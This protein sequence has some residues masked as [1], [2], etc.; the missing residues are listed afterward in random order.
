[1][2]ARLRFILALL[3][4]L[5]GANLSAQRAVDPAPHPD[6]PAAAKPQHNLTRLVL[7][8]RVEPDAAILRLVEPAFREHP[9]YRGAFQKPPC[10]DCTERVDRRTTHAKYYYHNSKPSEFTV[11]QSYYPL[12]YRDANGWLRTIDPRL[13]VAAADALVYE[14]PNQPAPTRLDLR[15]GFA[16]LRLPTGSELRVNETARVFIEGESG[17][18]LLGT[19]QLRPLNTKVG[20]DGAFQKSVV[21]GVDREIIFGKGS[22]K[23]NY[24]LNQRPEGMSASDRWIVEEEWTQPAGS[25]WM[26]A[27]GQGAMGRNGLWYGA[28]LLLRDNGDT[29]A[30]LRRADIHDAKADQPNRTI[31]GY[32]L[33]RE[34]G[35]TVVQL[36]VSGEWLTAA[37]VQYPVTVD[38][39]LEE[40]TSWPD[41]IPFK[42]TPAAMLPVPDPAGN[43]TCASRS[44]YC[45]TTM[46]VQLPPQ[47]KLSRVAFQ[48]MI[49]NQ[50]LPFNQGASAVAVASFFNSTCNISEVIFPGG[51]VG[52]YG[53]IRL[54]KGDKRGTQTQVGGE[55][56]ITPYQMTLPDSC[57]KPVCVP[58]TIPFEMRTYHCEC[59]T[60]NDIQCVPADVARSCMIIE[61]SDWVMVAQGNTVEPDVNSSAGRGDTL[62]V[63]QGDEVT[64]QAEAKYGVAPYIYDWQLG[65]N[66]ERAVIDNVTGFLSHRVDTLGTYQY[67]INYTDACNSG[68]DPITYTVIVRPGPS[69]EITDYKH[70]NCNGPGFVKLAVSENTDLPG[71]VL[72][73]ASCEI[74]NQP[75]SSVNQAAAELAYGGNRAPTTNNERNPFRGGYSDFRIQY[76]YPV[77]ILQA[78]G[79]QPGKIIELS[80]IQ[81]S[82]STIIP[83]RNLTIKLGCTNVRGL[84]RTAGFIPNLSTVFYRNEFDMPNV[85][86]GQP[87]VFPLDNAY[88]WD[89]TSHL[90]L[91]VCFDNESPLGGGDNVM[92][93]SFPAPASDRY[94]TV[95]WSDQPTN[96]NVSGCT[97]DAG[98]DLRN[99]YFFPVLR[100]RQC[101]GWQWNKNDGLYVST[102]PNREFDIPDLPSDPN[103]L[104]P[105]KYDFFYVDQQGCSVPV[106]IRID[107][108]PDP[109]LVVSEICPDTNGHNVRLIGSD[110]VREYEYEAR[111]TGTGTVVRSWRTDSTMFL[112]QGTYDIFIRDTS[113]CMGDAP[114]IEIGPPLE[115]VA[116]DTCSP[117]IIFTSRGGEGTTRTFRAVIESSTDTLINSDGNFGDLPPGI[118]FISVEDEKPCRVQRVGFLVSAPIEVAVSTNAC[119]STDITPNATVSVLNGSGHYRYATSENGPWQASPGFRLVAGTYTFYV[120][121]TVTGCT[122][123][124]SDVVVPAVLSFKVRRTCPAPVVNNLT[125]V[126]M[127]GGSGTYQYSVDNG[128][129]WS[130]MTAHRLPVGTHTV[131]IRDAN[132]TDCQQF[133]TAVIPDTMV[134]S[135]PC[136]TDD[137]QYVVTATGGEEPKEYRLTGTGG[138]D[139]TQANG[140]FTVL[141]PNQSGM[142]TAEVSYRLMPEDVLCV[143]SKRFELF[144]R[145]KLNEIP[146]PNDSGH[147]SLHAQGGNPA[148]YTFGWI[149]GGNDEQL[150]SGTKNPYAVTLPPGTRMYYV[151]DANGC[152]SEKQMTNI[153]R[154]KAVVS[155]CPDAD[156]VLTVTTDPAGQDVL[157]ALRGPSQPGTPQ[158]S[159]FTP[160]NPVGVKEYSIPADF[161]DGVPATYR[162]FIKYGDNE[163]FDSTVKAVNVPL[164]IDSLDIGCHVSGATVTVVVKTRTGVGAPASFRY[165][166]GD[167]PQPDDYGTA[168]NFSLSPGIHTL[169]VRD[170][171]GCTDSMSVEVVVPL[172]IDSVSA[173]PDADGNYRVHVSGGGEEF[174]YAVGENPQPGG[175]KPAPSAADEPRQLLLPASELATEAGFTVRAKGG[176]CSDFKEISAKVLKASVLTVNVTCKGD[177][178]GAIVVVIEGVV[179]AGA[180]VNLTGAVTRSKPINPL[181][182]GSAV[183]QDLPAGE[184]VIEVLNPTGCPVVLDTNRVTLSEPAD[185]FAVA[186]SADSVLC[187][188][189]SNGKIHVKDIVGAQGPLTFTLTDSEGGSGYNGPDVAPPSQWTYSNLPAGSYTL[190]VKDSLGCVA[191][192]NPDNPVIIHEPDSL[193]APLPIPNHISC[194]GGRL[195]E[196]TINPQGGTPPYRVIMTGDASRA[197]TQ[198]P[199]VFDNLDKRPDTTGRYHFKVRDAHGCEYEVP[200][201]IEIGQADKLGVEV[202]KIPPSCPDAKDGEII[203]EVTS[204]AANGNMIY[205]I[206]GMPQDTL[207]VAQVVKLPKTHAYKDLG[208]GQYRLEIKDSDS[209]AAKFDSTVYNVIPPPAFAASIDPIDAKCNGSDDGSVAVMV[210]SGGESQPVTYYLYDSANN[211]VNSQTEDQTPY[212]GYT[213]SPLPVGTYRMRV[214]YENTRGGFCE[215]T[216]RDNGAFDIKEPDRIIISNFE[217]LR[218]IS[219]HGDSALISFAVSGRPDGVEMTN[220]LTGGTL[221]TPVD[222]VD[223]VFFDIR[224]PGNYK[225]VSR[226]TSGCL[227]DTLRFTIDGPRAAFAFTGI[228][229]G[230]D[231]TCFGDNDGEFTLEVSG[232]SRTMSVPVPYRYDL[233]Y[234]DPANNETR[235]DDQVLPEPPLFTGMAPGTYTFI[236]RD[237]NNNASGN[238]CGVDTFSVEIIAKP[239]FIARSSVETDLECEGIGDGVILVERIAGGVEPVVVRLLA[240]GGAEQQPVDP[241]ANPLRYEGLSEAGVY[242]VE[243]ADAD[244][245]EATL[246]AGSASTLTAPNPINVTLEPTADAVKCKGESTG[247]I[248]VRATGG[249]GQL[250]YILSGGSLTSAIEQED[251]GTFVDL[252]AGVYE[253]VVRD[254]KGCEKSF[255]DIEITEPAEALAAPDPQVNPV[256]CFGANDGS[257]V[258]YATGGTEPYR[259]ALDTTAS[260]TNFRNEANFSDLAGTAAP[261]TE[262][263]YVIEDANGCKIEG[264]LHIIEPVKVESNLTDILQCS[265]IPLPYMLQVGPGTPAMGAWTSTTPEI[266]KGQGNGIGAVEITQYGSYELRYEFANCQSDPVRIV[267]YP[268]VSAGP[269]QEFCEGPT[270]PA[271][272]TNP[273]APSTGGVWSCVEGGATVNPTSGEISLS[274]LKPGLYTFRYEVSQECWDEFDLVIKRQPDAS[275]EIVTEPTTYRDADPIWYVDIDEIEFRNTSTPAPTN[276]YSWDMGDG[277]TYSDRDARHT[278]K[279]EKNAF[280][281]TLTVRDADGCEAKADTSV[282]VEKPPVLGYPSVFSPNGD[283]VNDELVL[284]PHPDYDVTAVIYDRWGNKLF[285]W[286]PD[287]PRWDGTVNGAAVPETAYFYTI[288]YRH[289][290]TGRQD[291]KKGTITLLR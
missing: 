107:S 155:A 115:L 58:S 42:N 185:T 123:S 24:I 61:A 69:A 267:I 209:C 206:F 290:V 47:A 151:V 51:G 221:E 141:Q 129:T 121:D 54:S 10:G 241:Q 80:F 109:K 74:A 46:E 144:P 99:T 158:L 39:L 261:G 183:F 149:N 230:K 232:G 273:F 212:Q 214:V 62:Y 233:I 9:E 153:G 112:P 64:F 152:R 283:G 94:N 59:E 202:R 120:R 138:Y 288:E 139:Q 219:C 181:N 249:V 140:T 13:Q 97:L 260:P 20:N 161:D 79:L 40:R 160:G 71:C 124:K 224:N 247:S 268:E 63:C 34:G 76:L 92:L 207:V 16:A 204:G 142:F 167:N 43:F 7:P 172:K 215:A 85:G 88:V 258:L 132:Q 159:D 73:S 4:V 237:G 282:R 78:A 200:D 25:R 35:R 254:D 156:S 93:F 147:A 36:V 96:A 128:A 133:T 259:Y 111:A 187:K 89:G 216:L 125:F 194:S 228:A 100:F 253:M 178:S 286:S 70:V 157:F 280:T 234:T 38:P 2:I 242:R 176:P 197:L 136:P 278:Y 131:G 186:V 203:V 162:F 239:E 166:V 182:D 148:R 29:L 116:V 117:G 31:G 289:R 213:Y 145:L 251:N 279:E 114:A 146:C 57:P 205:R 192:L 95:I 243:I 50:N 15:R 227:S 66:Y 284:V 173:C 217:I 269:D 198:P 130:G 196:I 180:L 126:E 168:V 236:V 37:H 137:N 229:K 248:T 135:T 65:G 165:A 23:T 21:E 235:T 143:Q 18:R 276:S 56:V 170:S 222:K 208:A 287:N 272:H 26:Y 281:V 264:S 231:E 250:T 134:I 12:H 33:I 122:A 75:V 113:G 41:V 118:Y 98:Q 53:G 45:S 127:A 101:F 32:R 5:L 199:Y 87:I 86:N 108:I 1:M 11:Y 77:A 17:S 164:E 191:K 60:A 81:Q 90:V 82:K 175:F 275:F 277:T 44:I 169:W 119:P 238:P 225:L 83:Y 105:G 270:L 177:T 211:L 255:T 103:G 154:I 262:Y 48:L 49:L 266:I 271:T 110:G 163:C 263:F 246:E 30:R 14:A 68:T 91:E 171:S 257:A 179:N 274:S 84:T 150:F 3:P 174:E 22:I 244:G 245:C 67:T 252:P 106:S 240:P 72:A 285:V 195:G 19:P 8:Q 223:I 188:D 201:T 291:V 226:D 256:S 218:E 104:R 184:Y 189:Q 6:V 102:Y 55:W 265:A 210:T 52:V 193:K 28:L 190:E 220:V 27:E